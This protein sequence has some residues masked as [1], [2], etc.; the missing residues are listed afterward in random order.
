[1]SRLTP[2]YRIVPNSARDEREATV[3]PSISSL[4]LDPHLFRSVPPRHC[5]TNAGISL[6]QGKP[7]VNA[8]AL[9]VPAVLLACTLQI[10]ASSLSFGEI[11]DVMILFPDL[12]ALIR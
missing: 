9:P 8:D 4:H 5:G 10:G 3:T 11:A 1:M 6:A 7:L 12:P 2:T